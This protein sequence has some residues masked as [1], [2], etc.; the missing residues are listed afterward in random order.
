MSKTKARKKIT[1]LVPPD[2]VDWM[3]EKIR[4]HRFASYTHAIV[5]ALQDMKDREQE[6]ILK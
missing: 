3:D 2:L 6:S 1:A 5:N 4:K